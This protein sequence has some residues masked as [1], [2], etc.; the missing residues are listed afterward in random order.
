MLLMG[1]PYFF[2]AYRSR[3]L[4]VAHCLS[5]F[6]CFSYVCVLL[7]AHHVLLMFA[8]CMLFTAQYVLLMFAIHKLFT[9]DY[10]LLMF[11]NCSLLIMCGACW[12]IVQG[13][14]CVAHNCTHVC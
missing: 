8:I 10:V 7:T 6:D 4:C 3:V 2:A 14:L 1:F 9:A 13:S 12:C 11:V 5:M